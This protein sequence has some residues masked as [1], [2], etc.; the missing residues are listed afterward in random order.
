M[1]GNFTCIKHPPPQPK[2]IGRLQVLVWF[3][4]TSNQNP[5]KKKIKNIYGKHIKVYLHLQILFNVNFFIVSVYLMPTRR[6]SIVSKNDPPLVP[7]PKKGQNKKQ[8]SG[9]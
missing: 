2:K 9:R 3:V 1:R 6:P 7:L 8:K 5:V 4:Q